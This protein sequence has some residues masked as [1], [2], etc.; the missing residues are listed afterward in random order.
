M[1]LTTRLL[2]GIARGY[3]RFAPG[4]V[5]KAGIVDHYLNA[6]LRARPVTRDVV[7]RNGVRICVDTKDIVQRYLY[8]FGIWE[9]SLTSW[10]TR[11]LQPG[12]VFVDVGANIGYYGLLAA[13]LVGHQG[14]VVAIEASPAAYAAL[15]RNVARNQAGNIR[16]VDRAVAARDEELTF[17]EPKPGVHSVTTSVRTSEDMA[18][19]F[20]V[21]ARPLP[22]LLTSQELS[23]ARV[24]KIDIEGG[25]YAALA[26]LVPAL[27]QTRQDLEIVVEVSESLLARQSRTIAD[28]VGLLTDRGFHPYR[29][30]NSYQPSSYLRAPVAPPRARG[31]ISGNAD[32]VFS[33]ADV[34][35]L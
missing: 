18:P 31:P 1:A 7:L 32:L 24:I 30:T 28:A 20:R 3:V 27:D 16:L 17:Y 8:Q 10:L 12:D 33:R 29:L 5:A 11:T 34:K 35:V 26:G 6:A 22:T 4:N 19:A 23:A 15:R 2:P 13:R 14:S 25:E 9:P 21:Q